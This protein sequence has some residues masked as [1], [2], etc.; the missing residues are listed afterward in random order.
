MMKNA[1]YFVLKYLFVLK[2]F[3]VFIKTARWTLNSGHLIEY[4]RK[5]FFLEKS[6]TKCGRETIPKSFSKKLKMSINH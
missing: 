4:K 2:M 5:N 1:F 6:Y 3:E